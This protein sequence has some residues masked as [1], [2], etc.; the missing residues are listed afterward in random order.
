MFIISTFFALKNIDTWKFTIAPISVVVILTS[1]IAFGNGELLV[2]LIYY[3]Q[4][5]RAVYIQPKEPIN[6]RLWV[7]LGT[8]T[9]LGILLIHYYNETV[10]MA[11][12]AGY[13]NGPAMLV[14]A[15]RNQLDITAQNR[16]RMANYSFIAA[17]AMAYN[18]SFI[19]LYN[20]L[21]F[22]KLRNSKYLLPVVMYIPFVILTTGRTDFIRLITLWLIIGCTF[23]RQKNSL[24]A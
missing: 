15:R 2:N 16:D 9:V 13:V 3:K 8:C 20:K 10:K 21:F 7:T 19:F 11:K 4:K 6:I 14:Y 23:F 5:R 24:N 17:G 18:F 22:P 12:E 1:F